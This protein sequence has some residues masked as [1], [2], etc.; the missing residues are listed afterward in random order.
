MRKTVYK[1]R[2]GRD[3]KVYW[4]GDLPLRIAFFIIN[5]IEIAI[6]VYLIVR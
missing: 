2:V 6:I 3:A 1:A 4:Y 5:I